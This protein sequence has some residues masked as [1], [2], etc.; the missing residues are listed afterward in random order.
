MVDLID[1]NLKAT[2]TKSWT[3]DGHYGFSKLPPKIK[4]HLE[5]YKI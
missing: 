3:E 1:K 4:D 5:K 2:Q